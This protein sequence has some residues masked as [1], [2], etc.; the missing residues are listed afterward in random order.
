VPVAVGR[1]ARRRASSVRE[2][3]ASFRY[4]RERVAS[5]VFG[6]TKSSAAISAFRSPRPASSATRSSVGVSASL[7]LRRPPSRRVSASTLVSHRGL[8][9]E[10]KIGKGVAGSAHVKV[11]A[12]KTTQIEIPLAKSALAKVAGTTAA[13]TFKIVLKTNG[14]PT[15]QTRAV[16]VSVPRA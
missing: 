13:A 15:T 16:S 8:R 6:V 14:R 12:G 11:G 5:T 4:T 7:A 2:R 9:R 3:T 1:A 10:A